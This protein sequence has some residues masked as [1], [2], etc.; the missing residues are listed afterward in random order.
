MA[1]D[2]QV[3]ITTWGHPS[4]AGMASRVAIPSVED[5]PAHIYHHHEPDA[6]S[7]GAARNRAVEICDP[8]EWICFL[9]A[10]DELEP[11]YIERMGRRIS[12][13][14]NDGTILFAPSLRLPGKEPEIY[15]DRDI[16][17]GMNPCPI[18]TLIHRDMFEEAG[19]FWG[20]SAWEDWSL[21]RRA[22][23]VGANIRFVPHAVYKANSTRG[24]RNSTVGNPRRL[25][26]DIIRSHEEWLP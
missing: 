14:G 4:W 1:V 21:F 19:Q 16:L 2:I 24:G 20:E 9:D 10:D 8:Q 6:A 25:Q 22:V 7:A 5:Q 11:H 15:P 3:I 23:L 17:T 26:R 12:H 18:G 13:F